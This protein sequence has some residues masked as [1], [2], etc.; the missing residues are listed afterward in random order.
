MTTIRYA[1]LIIFLIIVVALVLVL[2]DGFAIRRGALDGRHLVGIL[3]ASENISTS[4]LNL[5]STH[6]AS[7]TCVLERG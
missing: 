1:A 2:R 6:P 4:G 5:W 3:R 7:S